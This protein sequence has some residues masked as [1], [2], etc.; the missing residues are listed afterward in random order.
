MGKIKQLNVQNSQ[1][2]ASHHRRK[3]SL[4]SP[5]ANPPPFFKDIFR[6]GTFSGCKNQRMME[7]NIRV[8]NYATITNNHLDTFILTF[9][10]QDL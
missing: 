9:V 2:V 4:P 10:F 1:Y 5:L 8:L 7:E 6:K 3:N